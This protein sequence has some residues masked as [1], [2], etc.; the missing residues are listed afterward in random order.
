MTWGIDE[1]RW[2]Q[3]MSTERYHPWFGQH[4]RDEPVPGCE[5]V[6]GHLGIMVVGDEQGM[7]YEHTETLGGQHFRHTASAPI[8]DVVRP[9]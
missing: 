4:L 5:G 7:T 3:G 9:A 1:S 6:A 8:P 2:D